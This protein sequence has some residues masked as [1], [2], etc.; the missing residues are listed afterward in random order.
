MCF[1]HFKWVF[2]NIVVPQNGWFIMENPIK[3]D[4][5][6]YF[7]KHPNGH[8]LRKPEIFCQFFVFNSRDLR[9]VRRIQFFVSVRFDGK[10]NGKAIG[11]F[12][13]GKPW[14]GW[15]SLKICKIPSLKQSQRVET[16][17]NGWLEDDPASFWEG[18]FS[19]ANC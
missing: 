11:V 1:K 6:P 9:H 2:P 10:A 8:L 18:Q 17:E 15:T 16:P 14:I 3:V 19:G 12:T 5:L 7:W 13:P 4:D